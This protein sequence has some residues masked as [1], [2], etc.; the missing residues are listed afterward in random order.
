MEYLKKMK[1]IQNN[2]LEFLYD[3]EESQELFVDLS[4]LLNFQQDSPNINELESIL[5]LIS[6]ISKDH[7][8]KPF[9]FDRIKKIILLLKNEIK[10]TFS[11][12]KIFQLF[13]DNKAVLL[14]LIDED[15]LTLN[16]DILEEIKQIQNFFY[17]EIIKIDDKYKFYE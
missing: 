12:T 9:F 6:I 1:A 17:Q 10:Q 3:D 11:N 14:L 13:K 16:L 4:K 15:I 2:I 5:F 8:R 7:H